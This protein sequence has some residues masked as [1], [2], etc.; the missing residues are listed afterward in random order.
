MGRK[1]RTL[2]VGKFI[3]RTSREI[4][5]GQMY[6]IYIYYYWHGMQIRRSID[7][8]V[9]AKDWD[10]KANNGKGGFKS[11]YGRN[12]KEM[13]LRLCRM[14]GE[15]DNNIMK[16]VDLNGTINSDVITKFVNGEDDVLRP[17]NGLDFIK[18]GK[19]RFEQRYQNG[20]IGVSTWKNGISYLNQFAKYLNYEHQGTY[21]AYKEF[22]R[23]GDINVDIVSGFLKWYSKINKIDTVNKVL[24]CIA[25][26][27]KY[28]VKLG[29]LSPNIPL[30]IEDLHVPDKDL[31]G[32]D[33]DIKY[34]TEEELK[35]F[36]II[37]SCLLHPRQKDFHDMFMF[38]FYSCGLRLIDIITLRWE[39]IDSKR[40]LIK[41]VQ[42]KTRNRNVVPI[43]EPAERILERWQGRN[44]VYV[45]DLLDEN[46]E[47]SDDETLR[48][49]RNSIDSTIN[50][51]LKKQ[52]KDAKLE[53]SLTFHMARHT[54]AVLALQRG[55]NISKIGALLGHRTTA[56]TE[57]VYAEFL[58]DDLVDV[59]KTLNF[60][61]E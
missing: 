31:D 32:R 35:K 40:K 26:I 7:M 23:V 37:R 2:P 60:N 38:S 29:Y 59:V 36:S 4:N 28:A 21:G 52:A 44:K 27:C 20:Q 17:D 13:N 47:L 56:V 18:F 8:S 53:K 39:D 46:F 58:P 61:Y 25:Q 49:R 16:Y 30:E 54:W 57:K 15:I 11:T 22:I 33:L 41:K 55:T 51:S 45:F 3:L 19:Q 1:A 50:T 24:Q 10:E 12:Y 34:L 6:A 5:G 43:V 9:T 42:I 14:L 48:M